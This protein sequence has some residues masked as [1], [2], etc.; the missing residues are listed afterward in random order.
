MAPDMQAGLVCRALQLAI[1]QRR[2]APG[3]IVHTNRGSQY[4]SAVH[5]ALLAQHGPVGSMSR[6]GNCW[7]DAVIERFFPNLKMEHVWQRDYANHAEATSDIADYIVGCLR[8]RASA[9]HTGQLATQCLRAAIG[10]HLTYRCV[11]NNLTR[12]IWSG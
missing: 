8:Q 2:P 9:L 10:N 4:A 5:Q 1:L 7:D 6:K 11:R 3:L 12:T